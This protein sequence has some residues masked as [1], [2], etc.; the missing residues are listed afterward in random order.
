MDN[1]PQTSIF[2][3]DAPAEVFLSTGFS[4]NACL[5]YRRFATAAQAIQFVVESKQTTT[6]TGTV[7]EVEEERFD[8]D[9][10]YRLYAASA[11]PLPRKS[12]TPLTAPPNRPAGRR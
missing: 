2:D 11:Y 6:L 10:I 1:E 7:L 8:R 9:A 4:R 3:Y 12:G 5:K